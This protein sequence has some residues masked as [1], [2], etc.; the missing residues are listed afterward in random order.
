MR[1]SEAPADRPSGPGIGDAG[2]AG[3]FG[4]D[5]PG[6]DTRKRRD[7]GPGAYPLA[8]LGARVAVAVP[9]AALTVALVLQGGV[10]LAVSLSLLGAAAA[11]ELYRLLGGVGAAR[12]AGVVAVLLLPLA[13]LDDGPPAM[14]LV[15][16]AALPAA[17]AL[18]GARPE[19]SRQVADTMLGVVWI[20]V[21][22]AH[23]TLLRELSGGDL[24]AIGVL[25]G[26]FL[27][28]T[29]AHLLGSAFGRRQL[30]PRISP[31]KTLEGLLA[32]IVAGTLS[33]WLFMTLA[34]GPIDGLDA[35]LLGLAVTIAAPVG[36]LFESL[37]K[38][39]AGR[40]DS[41]RA[42]GAHGGVLDRVDATL[43]SVVAG[44]YVA[45]L[46]V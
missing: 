44:Y 16:V 29:A 19:A 42:F 11:W 36:D 4:F 2:P 5:Y 35:V 12:I 9:A 26:T 33:L 25:L 22:L 17:F 20:G 15:V 45:Q 34:D 43:F 27:G 8:D 38:R 28:D 31:A 41:G 1:S 7:A 18:T 37:V 13:A 21:A 40:K 10:L 3:E 32:G 24:L 46:L 6:R 23:G 14:L 30:A 39:G